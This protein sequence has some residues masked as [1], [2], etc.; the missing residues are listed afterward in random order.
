MRTVIINTYRMNRNDQT[1]TTLRF[2]HWTR[3]GYAV[4]A[5]LGQCVTIGQLRK[6]ITE[7]ALTKQTEPGLV[8]SPEGVKADSETTPSIL[9]APDIALLP[10]T[11]PLFTETADVTPC[12][13]PS[14]PIVYPIHRNIDAPSASCN[15]YPSTRAY[16]CCKTHS[17]HLHLCLYTPPLKETSYEY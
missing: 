12:R 13:V 7:R 11:I 9:P 16:E 2:R 4:F 5:S 6:N 3:K 14:H 1:R 8:S 17:V 10:I 15:F